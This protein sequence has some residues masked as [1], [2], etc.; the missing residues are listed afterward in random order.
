MKV[1]LEE[2]KTSGHYGLVSGE[3]WNSFFEEN[4]VFLGAE[5]NRYLEK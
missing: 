3:N 4:R 5:V 1:D 2:L